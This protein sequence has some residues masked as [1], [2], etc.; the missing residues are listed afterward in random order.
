MF[1]SVPCINNRLALNM[2]DPDPKAGLTPE[3]V[4]FISSR[5]SLRLVAQFTDNQPPA[6]EQLPESFSYYSTSRRSTPPLDSSPPS[7]TSIHFSEANRLSL[8][9]PEPDEEVLTDTAIDTQD[10]R[11]SRASFD[12]FESAHSEASH[13]TYTT[14]R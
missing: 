1:V 10:H 8:A 2:S 4:E 7:P 9:L 13:A 6:F 12:S 5:E 3:Q 14:A 11:I